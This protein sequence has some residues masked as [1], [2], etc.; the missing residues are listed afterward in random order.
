[1]NQNPEL[2][3]AGLDALWKLYY[4]P[5]HT[6]TRAEFE[7]EFGV[8]ENHFGLFCRG[9]AAELG[10]DDLDVLALANSSRNEAGFEI[11]ILKPS[12]VTAI[13]SFAFSK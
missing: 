6:L 9:V 7:K 12:V 2:R 10:A 3:Q 1:V 11:I 5:Q 13:R 4:A 8:L